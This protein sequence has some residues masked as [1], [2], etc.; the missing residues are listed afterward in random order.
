MNFIDKPVL[1]GK[2]V[3]GGRLQ[4]PVSVRERLGLKDG[5][6]VTMEVID[7]EL[8][9]RTDRGG[10]RRAQELVRHLMPKDGT[11]LSDELI[12]DRRR[13]AENE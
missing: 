3:S 7:N 4:V 12:A 11:R 8:V 13:E 5:D 10:V 6:V 1:T 9:I 2:I